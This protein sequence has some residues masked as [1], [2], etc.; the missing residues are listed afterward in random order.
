MAEFETKI[1]PLTE[2]VKRGWRIEID[3]VTME[4]PSS[5]EII[6]EK[7][8]Q[9]TYGKSPSGEYDQWAFH[10]VGGGGSV[11]IPFSIVGKELWVGVVIQPRPLQSESPVPNVPRGF[12]D[13]KESHFQ[14]AASE[15][16]EEMGLVDF[17]VVNLGGEGGNP[18]NTFFETWGEDEGIHFWAVEV[19]AN[20]L[21]AGES[22]YGFKPGA[23]QPIK[24][25]KMAERILGSKFVLWTEAAK[26]GDMM[27][28]SAITRLLANLANNG[29]V[30]LQTKIDKS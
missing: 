4:I 1:R 20:F 27:T 15:L 12:M 8:G 22:Q 21:V 24:G 7:L 11:I 2:E 18:N 26:F 25:D 28:L 19:P 16:A 23:V 30:T 29:R 14:A 17:P 9:L 10:E 3:D 13:P 6:H 5:L